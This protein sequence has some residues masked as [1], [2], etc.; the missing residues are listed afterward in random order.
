LLSQA[1]ARKRCASCACWSGQRQPGPTPGWVNI[2]SELD[3]GLCVGG[4]W[5][6]DERRAR[7]ACGHWKIWPLVAD[8]NSK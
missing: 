6:G 7:S 1:V 4:G 3:T 8:Q 5:D 2:D